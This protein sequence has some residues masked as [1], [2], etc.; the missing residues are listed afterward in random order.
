MDD[1]NMGTYPGVPS[2]ATAFRSGDSEGKTVRWP[3]A[4]A[5]GR[6]CRPRQGFVCVRRQGRR[7]DREDIAPARDLADGAPR[8]VANRYRVVG[9]LRQPHATRGRSGALPL[10]TRGSSACKPLR[11]MSRMARRSVS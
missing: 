6:E 1:V 11:S 10:T 9:A 5:G 2:G 8:V 4:H 3:R 7:R